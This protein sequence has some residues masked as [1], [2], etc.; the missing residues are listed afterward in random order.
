[1]LVSEELNSLFEAGASVFGS[2][3]EKIGTLN[4]IDLNDRTGIPRFATVRMGFLG[5]T[6][7]LVPL[8]EAEVSNGNLYVKFPRDCVKRA[9]TI[10][11]SVN[12]SPEDEQSLYGY[13]SRACPGNP[14]SMVEADPS[15]SADNSDSRPKTVQSVPHRAPRQG[16]CAHSATAPDK[17]MGR[18]DHWGP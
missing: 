9:P 11:P 14:G 17:P 16:S 15:R 3:G 7:R 1:M 8:G 5:S 18:T 10:Y 12:L 13:Y 4:R 6:E 2:D